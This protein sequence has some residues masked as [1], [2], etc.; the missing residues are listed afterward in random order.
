MQQAY[1]VVYPIN[2]VVLIQV[3]QKHHFASV[4]QAVD[5]YRT[6]AIAQTFFGEK[7]I[8]SACGNETAR[9]AYLG[10]AGSSFQ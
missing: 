1:S 4:G 6:Q 3:S 9:E 8:G 10:L 7:W 2:S 5:N